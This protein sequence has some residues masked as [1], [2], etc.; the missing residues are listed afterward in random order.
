MSAETDLNTTLTASTEVTS[1][2][3]TRIYS[4]VA[5]KEAA[6]P[7]IA[8]SRVDT[9]YVRTI[10]G[11][12]AAE[13]VTLEVWCMATRRGDAERIA[14]A[15]EPVISSQQFILTGRRPEFDEASEV[16]SAVLT[17]DYWQT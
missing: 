11:T 2:V 16:Y 1:R 3:S 17:V 8:F 14:D 13:R 9:E 5:P 6:L 12:R 4:D 10:H 7:C 15:V